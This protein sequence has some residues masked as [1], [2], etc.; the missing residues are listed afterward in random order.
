MKGGSKD[1]WSLPSR[2]RRNWWVPHSC[3]AEVGG[4]KSWKP[5]WV[6]DWD[7]LPWAG[8]MLIFS[9]IIPILVYV[10]PKRAQTETVSKNPKECH[11]KTHYFYARLNFLLKNRK[12]LMKF[13]GKSRLSHSGKKMKWAGNSLVSENCRSTVSITKVTNDTGF[14]Y[15]ISVQPIVEQ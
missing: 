14:S 12:L 5:S 1:R 10:L 13:A 7:S 8:A 2:H 3:K 15:P 4:V 9:V 11:D 6:T